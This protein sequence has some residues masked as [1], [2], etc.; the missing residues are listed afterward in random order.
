MTPPSPERSRLQLLMDRL[1]DLELRIGLPHERAILEVARSA[2]HAEIH[3]LAHRLGE[4][5]YWR[6]QRPAAQRAG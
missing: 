2:L 4:R 1:H 3:T 5:D 6:H